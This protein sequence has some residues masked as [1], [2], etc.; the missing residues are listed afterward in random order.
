MSDQPIDTTNKFLVASQGD[1][2]VFLRP[3]PQRISTA[4][5][6]VLAAYIVAM[7]GDED[8]WLKVYNAVCEI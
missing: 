8:E 5:A 4:D 7:N 3:L 6:L 2:I 1:D